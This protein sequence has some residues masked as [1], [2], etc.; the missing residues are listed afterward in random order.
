[1]GGRAK[2][3]I[4]ASGNF[5]FLSSEIRLHTKNQLPGLLGSALNFLWWV[6]GGPTNYFV[7]PNFSWG[8]VGLWQLYFCVHNSYKRDTHM[9]IAL[10]I[11]RY[12][13]MYNLTLPTHTNCTYY[14][15]ISCT[16]VR[17]SL[18]PVSV[19]LYCK[20][21]LTKESPSKI[22]FMNRVDQSKLRFLGVPI[23]QRKQST[24][25]Y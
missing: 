25:R 1:M 21:V 11:F 13:L 5:P 23:S 20:L 18:S 12:I 14:A 2:T 4:G 17:L 15:W 19:H 3:P 22:T 9:D 8:W 16:D 6:G 24:Q 7:T 10:Y